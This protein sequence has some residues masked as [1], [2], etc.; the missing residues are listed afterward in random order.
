MRISKE[1]RQLSRQLLRASFVDGILDEKKVAAL[2]DSIIANK[3]RDFIRLL[4]NYRRLLRLEVEKQRAT[5]ESAV[6]LGP[7]AGR[8]IAAG[9]QRK[10]GDGLKT[11]F[12]VNT[13]L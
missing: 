6:P 13:R 10:Y 2:V 4:E 11:G 7:E 8:Q 1:I 5:I 3:P 12:V 9:V